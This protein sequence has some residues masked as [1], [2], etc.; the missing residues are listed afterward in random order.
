[1]VSLALIPLSFLVVLTVCCIILIWKESTPA[2]KRTK[3]L[4]I[5]GL[6]RVLLAATLTLSVMGLHDNDSKQSR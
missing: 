2:P 1:M 3:K 5:C 6:L 4:I